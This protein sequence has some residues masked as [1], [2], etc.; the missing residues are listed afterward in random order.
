MP[1]CTNMLEKIWKIWCWFGTFC[2]IWTSQ[3]VHFS[4]LALGFCGVDGYSWKAREDCFDLLVL[5]PF[6]SFKISLSSCPPAQWPFKRSTASRKRPRV[7]SLERTWHLMSSKQQVY[8][9]MKEMV[10]ISL[11]H[12]HGTCCPIHA[13]CTVAYLPKPWPYCAKHYRS[14]AIDQRETVVYTHKTKTS[15]QLKSTWTVQN[16][17]SGCLT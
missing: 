13:Q 3:K 11:C 2:V 5:H 12:C 4:I 17:A 14:E 10:I 9:D 6:W 15:T 8:F 16:W 7:V 1:W